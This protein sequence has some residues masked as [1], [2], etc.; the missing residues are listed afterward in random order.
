MINNDLASAF[1]RLKRVLDR[2]H[3]HRELRLTERHEKKGY[4]RRRLASERWRRRFAHEVCSEPSSCVRNGCEKVMS[5]VRKK[6]Q[7]VNEIRARG[8]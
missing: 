5:Q 3:V 8:A 6:V 1:V 4:K 2:N 7:L